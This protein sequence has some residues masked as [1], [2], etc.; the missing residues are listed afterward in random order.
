MA[1]RISRATK[2]IR[3]AGA[4]TDVGIAT[5]G[6]EIDMGG[7]GSLIHG[8]AAAPRLY[9]GATLCVGRPPSSRRGD[10]G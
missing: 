8:S 9:P 10:S 2:R 4:F 1:Q 6:I 5:N 7:R 3:Q